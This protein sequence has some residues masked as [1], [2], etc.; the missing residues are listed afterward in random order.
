LLDTQFKIPGVGTRVGIDPVISAVPYVGDVVSTAMSLYIVYLMR[1]FKVPWWVA[2]RMIGNVVL[3]GAVGIIPGIGS[4][5]DVAY[6]PNRRN[7]LLLEDYLRKQAVEKLGMD[8]KKVDEDIL[9]TRQDLTGSKD[10]PPGEDEDDVLDEIVEGERKQKAPIGRK[11]TMKT[12]RVTDEM[13]GGFNFP[14]SQ[15]SPCIYPS[16]SEH[17]GAAPS[18][19]PDKAPE[20]STLD[21]GSGSSGPRGQGHDMFE[22]DRDKSVYPSV[23]PPP[24]PPRNVTKRR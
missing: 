11:P 5:F 17:L 19:F 13:P 14:R 18:A 7:L 4:L 20:Y 6:K 8:P 1:R 9:R 3:N 16:V 2:L 21:R 23:P 24:L 12:G 15:P 22:Y 10:L